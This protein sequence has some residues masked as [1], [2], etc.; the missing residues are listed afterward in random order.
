M[1]YLENPYELDEFVNRSKAAKDLMEKTK[2]K[3]EQNM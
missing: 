3:K 1:E 2:G